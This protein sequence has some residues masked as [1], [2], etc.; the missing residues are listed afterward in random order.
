MWK[1]EK[2]EFRKAKNGEKETYDRNTT[3]TTTIRQQQLTNNNY[4]YSIQLQQHA[5]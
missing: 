4:S 1:F 3:T 5:M 2:F